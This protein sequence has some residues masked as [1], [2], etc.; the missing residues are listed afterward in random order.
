MGR[1]EGNLQ[2]KKGGRGPK[3]KKERDPRAMSGSVLR[4]V[5]NLKMIQ[6]H[7][8]KEVN[9]RMLLTVQMTLAELNPRV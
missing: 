5:T 3:A 4:A 8:I 1:G 2:V 9:K 7:L 6:L